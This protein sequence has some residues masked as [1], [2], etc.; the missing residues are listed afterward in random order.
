MT[1]SSGQLMLRPLGADLMAEIPPSERYA[2]AARGWLD[3]VLTEVFPDLLDGLHTG[4]VTKPVHLQFDTGPL[5]EPGQL[6]GEL[7]VGITNPLP[8]RTVLFTD[9]AWQRMLRSLDKS[10]V[11]A[12]LSI[13]ALGRDGYPSDDG[14]HI[15]VERSPLEPAWARFTFSAPVSFSWRPRYAESPRPG[16][17]TVKVLRDRPGS[18]EPVVVEQDANYREEVPGPGGGWPGSP[19]LQDRW[20]GFVQAQAARI[21]ACAGLLTDDGVPGLQTALEQAIFS[22][23]NAYPYRRRKVL[24]GYSWVTIVPPELAARLGGAPALA[25]GG[26]FHEVRELPDGSVWLRATPAI[27][28][29]TGERVRAVFETLAPVLMRGRTKFMF[30]QEQWPPRL[31][32]GVNAADYQQKAQRRER[33][34]RR[35]GKPAPGPSPAQVHDEAATPAPPALLERLPAGLPSGRLVIPDPQYAPYTGGA[36]VVKPVMWVSDQPVPNAT[37]MW[38]RLLIQHQVTGL[39]PLLLTAHDGVSGGPARPWHTGELAP[40]P[41]GAETEP[42]VDT[43]L[44]D[45]WRLHGGVDVD[46]GP[47]AIPA[48]PFPSWPGL[49]EPGTTMADKVRFAASHATETDISNLTGRADP[50]YLGLVPASD[51][52]AVI[53]AVGWLA[54]GGGPAET[55]AVLRSWQDRFGAQLVSLGLDTLVLIVERPPRDLEHARHVAAEHLA[56][57]PDLADMLPF[58]EYAQQLID[59]PT[60]GFWW[61]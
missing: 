30:A 34:A 54:P 19:A 50:P 32:E 51:G 6:L 28:D 61:D 38:A 35:P 20:A 24:Y 37:T 22:P 27:N 47:D 33:P 41:V 46:F 29:F 14:A 53:P 49:A 4:A 8:R 23:D 13:R 9:A 18:D 60:W 39:W 11:T 56:F 7:L 31:A 42:D 59:S 52:A 40:V 2:D 12:S 5:G 10:P 17:P 16:D 21:G 25:A 57:C 43:V 48:L 55:S 15:G 58:D 3:G 26:T 36:P 44:A 1:V 45:S